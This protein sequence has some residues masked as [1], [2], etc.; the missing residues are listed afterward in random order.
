L[1][2]LVLD[3]V[4]RI[5][6]HEFGASWDATLDICSAA[7]HAVAQGS[8]PDALQQRL[9]QALGLKGVVELVLLAS[10]GALPTSNPGSAV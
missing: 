4:L 8:L 9:Q 2:E 7:R 10:T 1:E 6:D 3:T 5:N